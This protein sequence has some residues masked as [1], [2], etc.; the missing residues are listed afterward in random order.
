MVRGEIAIGGENKTKS[1]FRSNEAGSVTSGHLI[2]E[3][4]TAK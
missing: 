2:V 1:Y 4:S 3:A